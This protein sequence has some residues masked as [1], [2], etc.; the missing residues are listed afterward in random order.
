SVRHYF[1]DHS[2]LLVAAATEVGDRMGKRLTRYEIDTFTG[3]TG[4]RAVDALQRLLEELLPIDE[5]RRV[6]SIVLTEFIIAARVNP[7]FRPVTERMAADMRTVIA[8]ALRVL[9]VPEP[10]E[11]AE[12]L[13][14]LMGGLIIDSV[15]PHGSLSVDR[16]R[17]TLRGHLRSMPI[18]ATDA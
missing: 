11:E 17:K 3:Y 2:H 18:P 12:R 5:T 13:V 6:E 9:E 4:E 15:T 14:A 8:H 16:L 7:I 10:V 1:D